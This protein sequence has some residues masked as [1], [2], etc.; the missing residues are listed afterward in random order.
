MSSVNF[1]LL[2]AFSCIMMHMLPLGLAQIPVRV[3]FTCIYM[4]SSL[5]ATFTI[6]HVHR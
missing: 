3:D 6:A 5:G 4:Y 1:A 2:A